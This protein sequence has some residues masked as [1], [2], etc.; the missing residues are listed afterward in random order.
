MV[1]SGL[2]SVPVVQQIEELAAVNFVKGQIEGQI[3]VVPL[4]RVRSLDCAYQQLDDVGSS[5]DVEAWHLS[6]AGAHHSEG[7]A[8][9]C[10]AV[11]EASRFGALE[12]LRN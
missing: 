1:F 9:A 6:V 11:G 3:S 5:Q 2:H 4:S 12:G 8:G 7:L 10:L